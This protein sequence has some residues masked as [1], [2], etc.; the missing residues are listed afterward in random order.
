MYAIRSYYAGAIEATIQTSWGQI[1]S[2]QSLIY[3][4]DTNEANRNV[5][6]AGFDG[7]LDAEEAAKFTDY[8]GYSDPA[9][10]N[11]QFYLTATGDVINRY[12]SYNA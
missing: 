2:S 9:G 10:D 4:F 6:D 8:A 7:L 11:Y 12:K 5:Q 1:P 3:A